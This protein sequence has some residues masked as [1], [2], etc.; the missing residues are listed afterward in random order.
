MTKPVCFLDCPFTFER[1]DCKAIVTEMTKDFVK[2]D[3]VLG[4]RRGKGSDIIDIDVNVRNA[5]EDIYHDGLSNV[6]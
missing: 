6:W 1:I 4:P 5:S 2:E 3:E